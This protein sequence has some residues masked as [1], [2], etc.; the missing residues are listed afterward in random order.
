M[1]GDTN[2][3][4]GVFVRDLQGGVT[5]LVSVGARSAAQPSGAIMDTPVM[6]P[7]GRFVAFSSSA[8]DLVN[9]AQTDYLEVY[10]RDVLLGQTF[11]ASTNLAS[12]T[13]AVSFAPALSDD[14]RFVS[15]KTTTGGNSWPWL[16][17]RDLHTGQLDVI[18]TNM[19]GIGPIVP[20]SYGPVMTPDGRLV[21]FTERPSADHRSSVWLWDA[22]TQTASVAS[23]H[24]RQRRILSARPG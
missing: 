14:G 8:L 13:T 16:L 3:I 9:A 4:A 23:V 1:T 19:A 24:G 15:F 17:R 20:D 7:D 22:Q 12:G 18:S 5:T 10:V 6:T 11:W 2:R 21:A